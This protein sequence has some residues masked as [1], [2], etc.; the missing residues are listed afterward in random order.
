MKTL[1]VGAG[2]AGLYLAYLLRRG[3]LAQQID[4]VEQNPPDATFGFGVVF[5]D[6]ALEFLRDDDAETYDLIAPAMERWTDLALYH[7]GEKI[8]IDGIGFAAVGRLKLL[9]LMQRRLLSVGLAPRYGHALTSSHELQGYD[10]V[11]GADGANSFVRRQQEDAFGTRVEPLDNRFVWYGTP[12]RFDTLSQ[13]FVATADGHFNAHHYR[14]SAGMS[15]FIVECDADTWQRAGFAQMDEEQTQ[16][17]CEQV[18]RDTLVG[19]PLVR[20]KSVWRR[21]PKVS[22]QR[23][24]S[25]RTVLI[26]DALRTAHFSI[27][28]GTRLALEDAIALAKAIEAHPDSVPDAL[29]A[30]EAARKPIVDKLFAAANASA[31]WYE[32]FARHMTLAPWDFAWSYIQRSGRVDIERLRQ[33]SPRFVA[34]Y[35]AHRAAQAGG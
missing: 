10:L 7:R 17:R 35:E 28:S 29:A 16:A 23:Y 19:A 11:V 31:A 1:I 2:P 4:I 6:R 34:G 9:Q 22:N 13:T 30:Y 12:R 18:F 24:H 15:T 14:Y 5:S 33:V 3:G 20:N 8:T 21:F 26:G 27:G 32:H 25:G